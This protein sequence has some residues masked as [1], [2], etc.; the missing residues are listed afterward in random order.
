MG[1][2]PWRQSPLLYGEGQRSLQKLREELKAENEGARVPS[3][4]RWLGG[5]ETRTRFRERRLLRSSVVLAVVRRG[6]GNPPLQAGGP[7]CGPPLGGRVLQGG[8]AGCLLQPALCVG[9]RRP[10]VPSGSPQVCPLQG[11]PPGVRPPVPRRGVGVT[12]PTAQGAQGVSLSRGRGLRGPVTGKEGG[13]RSR[14][15][16]GPRPGGGDG[17]VGSQRDA[18]GFLFLLFFFSLFLFLCLGWRS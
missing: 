17:G 11:G 12:L 10:S 6:G 14:C 8:P 2:Y 5:A 1:E 16:R 3:A 13:W 9:P 4:A 18:D 15:S 7:P